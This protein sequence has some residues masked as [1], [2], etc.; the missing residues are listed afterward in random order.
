MVA[1]Q[2]VMPLVACCSG[3]RGDG[4]STRTVLIA[5]FQ[6]VVHAFEFGILDVSL[7]RSS[8]LRWSHLIHNMCFLH[9]AEDIQVGCANSPPL[10]TCIFSFPHSCGY[11]P[12][13][14]PLFLLS[15]FLQG[16]PVVALLCSDS[17][18]ECSHTCV[19][20]VVPVLL[21]STPDQSP[22]FAEGLYLLV[23]E[24]A[25]FP[26]SYLQSLL[27]Q[28]ARVYLCL[29]SRFHGFKILFASAFFSRLF[30]NAEMWSWTR[31]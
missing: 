21:P 16:L 5:A 31:R 24:N 23:Q 9:R 8:V 18:E 15:I 22:T 1:S 10:C 11:I 17:A 4:N 7:V 30:W 25:H 28:R 2:V 27:R 26:T 14:I 12:L 13:R 3:D 6:G 19:H 20:T 29:S